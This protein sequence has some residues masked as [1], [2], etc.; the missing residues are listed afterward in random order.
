MVLPLYRIDEGRRPRLGNRGNTGLWYDKFCDAWNQG[1]SM[2]AE[3]G[4]QSPKSGKNEWIE[5]ATRST[6]GD[7]DL[8]GEHTARVARLV[9]ARGGRFGVFEAAS[10][11]VTGLGR[12]HPVENGFAWHHTLGTPYL[13][14][15]SIKGLVRSWV[16]EWTDEPPEDVDR[17]FGKGGSVGAVCFLDAIPTRS[18]RLEEDVIT[19]HY[20]GWD[21]G[22]PPGDWRSPVP[23]PFLVTAAGAKLLF[24]VLPRAGAAPED[25]ER[26]WT[27]IEEALDWAGAGAK[28]AVGYG[29]FT[30][31]SGAT[32]RLDEKL[33]ATPPEPARP[34][35]RWEREIRGKTEQQVLDLVRIHLEKG[36]IDDPEERRD[37]LHSVMS[38]GWVEQWKR[39]KKADPAT[40]MGAKKLKERAKLVKRALGKLE[41]EPGS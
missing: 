5:K 31:D 35:S 1:W 28:T 9:A 8:L 40:S 27:W 10:R 41:D 11:F 13:P 21:E 4:S 16:R 23:I 2:A 20:A 22:E 18:P 29:R 19:P 12:S 32:G 33:K 6:A 39:G 24:A 30:L 17:I 25:L 14:G 38:T 37:F 36:N 3:K 26:V 15:S 7:G 34:L